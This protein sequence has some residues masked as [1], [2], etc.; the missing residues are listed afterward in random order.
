MTKKE[1]KRN[2]LWG[3]LR[4]VIEMSE[5]AV[6]DT[7]KLGMGAKGRADVPRYQVII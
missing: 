2:E 5:K 6:V 1:I 3:N 7:P 4:D